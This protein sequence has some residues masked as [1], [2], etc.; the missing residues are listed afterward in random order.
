MTS[1]IREWA[2]G[3][4]IIKNTQYM[5]QKAEER[6]DAPSF[7]ALLFAGILDLRTIPPLAFRCSPQRLLHLLLHRC[8]MDRPEFLN[9]LPE[10]VLQ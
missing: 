9:G 6:G 2:S 8:R 5:A 10:G 7:L 1:G 3:C 4:N